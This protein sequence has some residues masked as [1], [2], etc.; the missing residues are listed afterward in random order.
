MFI[1]IWALD[2]K[3]DVPNDLMEKFN[4]DPRRKKRAIILKVFR[5]PAGI[6]LNWD[7]VFDNLRIKLRYTSGNLVRN[8]VKF[9]V[10][11]MFFLN[12]RQGAISVKNAAEIAKIPM[13]RTRPINLGDIPREIW[14][15]DLPR[16]WFLR[17]DSVNLWSP[18]CAITTGFPLNWAKTKT[19][20]DEKIRFDIQ[21]AIGYRAF[22]GVAH[23]KGAQILHSCL[24]QA[25]ARAAICLGAAR[26]VGDKSTEVALDEVQDSENFA[27]L[28]EVFGDN[29][30]SEVVATLLNVLNIRLFRPDNRF[31]TFDRKM[32]NLSFCDWPSMLLLWLVEKLHP[33]G[34]SISLVCQDQYSMAHFLNSTLKGNFKVHKDLLEWTWEQICDPKDF[35]ADLVFEK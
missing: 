29:K 20:R 19:I 12:I 22:G 35:F 26:V 27:N 9:A 32:E 8:M 33:E 14:E 1:I 23:A 17:S 24:D 3:L 25:P 5:R 10:D 28:R 6:F 18:V 21:I 2:N 30:L 13:N 7:E 16:H 15:D 31:K 34:I 11:S 4:Q